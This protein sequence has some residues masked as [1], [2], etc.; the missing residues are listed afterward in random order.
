MASGEP[1]GN[2][3]FY[4]VGHAEPGQHGADHP[5]H[6]D[7]VE[8]DTVLHAGHEMLDVPYGA[9]VQ[10]Q[11]TG[12]AVEARKADSL[13]LSLE[14]L[15][16]DEPRDVGIGDYRPDYLGPSATGHIR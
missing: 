4:R 5:Q 2:I 13:G 12:V 16:I 3:W 1:A 6:A 11:R 10:G 7:G 14:D 8:G 15:S 9:G